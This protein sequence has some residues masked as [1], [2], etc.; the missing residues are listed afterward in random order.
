VTARAGTG[1]LAQRLLEHHL[2]GDCR[3]VDLELSPRLYGL[4][5]SRLQRLAPRAELL[6]G[7]GS[8]WLSFESGEFD[9]CLAPTCWTC[10]ARVTSDSGSPRHST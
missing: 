10:S 2:R 6:L 9:R 8:L 5:R 4:A 7:D 1:A 3:H